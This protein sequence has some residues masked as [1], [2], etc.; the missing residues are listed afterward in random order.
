[1]GCSPHS[2]GL[3]IR[4]RLSSE[5]AVRAAVTALAPETGTSRRFSVDVRADGNCLVVSVTARD[6]SALRAALNSYAR[7]VHLIANL[8]KLV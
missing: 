4:E 6:L 8:D 7:W 5:S 3:V 2:I 1:M